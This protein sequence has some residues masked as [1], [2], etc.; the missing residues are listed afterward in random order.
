[1][2]NGLMPRGQIAKTLQHFSPAIDAIRVR[3]G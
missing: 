3:T 1:M 2:N